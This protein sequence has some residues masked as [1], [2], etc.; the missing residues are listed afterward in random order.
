MLFRLSCDFE[1]VFKV[2]IKPGN[3]K[4]E[5]YFTAVVNLVN[6]ASFQATAEDR[7]EAKKFAF[8]KA[9][10]YFQTLCDKFNQALSGAPKSPSPSLRSNAS[11]VST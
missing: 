10:P 8:E 7:E 2:N 6:F 5:P 11:V 9:F 3:S 1:E 4:K